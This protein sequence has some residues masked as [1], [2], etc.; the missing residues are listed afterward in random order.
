MYSHSILR[1][2]CTVIELLK[3]PEGALPNKKV[4]GLHAVLLILIRT[5][6]GYSLLENAEK[7]Y[8]E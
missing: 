5:Q 1:K 2:L 6:Y 4:K 3:I 8:P 7:Y